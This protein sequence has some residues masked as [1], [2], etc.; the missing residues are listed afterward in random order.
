MSRA[1]ASA[2]VSLAHPFAPQPTAGAPMRFQSLP[3]ASLL[4][5]ALSLLTMAVLAAPASAQI[6]SPDCPQGQIGTPPD[7]FALPGVGNGCPDGQ[8]GTP[9]D[10]T[11]LPAGCPA[12]QVGSPPDCST[13]P[14]ECPAGQTGTPPDCTTPPATCPAGQSGTPPTC[15]TPAATCPAGQTG[16][17]PACAAPAAT[18]TATGTS[19]PPASSRIIRR[20]VELGRGCSV[21]LLSVS[22]GAKVVFAKRLTP[23]R[24]RLTLRVFAGVTGRRMLRVKRGKRTITLAKPIR[25]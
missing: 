8:F 21:R 24:C 18:T 6:P 10:C 19:S 5:C 11:A 2:E 3:A 20:T 13:P 7:C 1:V 14:A 9:P 4:A 23:V 16:T 22:S 12:G 17:P 15:T 25:L